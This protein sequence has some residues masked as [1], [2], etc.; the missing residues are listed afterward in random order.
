MMPLGLLNPGEQGEIIAVRPHGHKASCCGKCGGEQG[1]TEEMG[2]R[3]GKMVQML[4]NGG[5]GPILLKIDESRIA[6]DRGL[7]MKIMIKEVLQ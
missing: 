1:R 6:L 2:L 4:N 5:G 7:A 3:I